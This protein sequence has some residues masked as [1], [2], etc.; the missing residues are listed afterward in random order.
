MQDKKIVCFNNFFLLSLELIQDEKNTHTQ[1]NFLLNMEEFFLKLCS[2]L[3][4]KNADFLEFIFCVYFSEIT[5]KIKMADSSTKDSFTSLL[6]FI[7]GAYSRI[8]PDASSS[9]LESLYQ[10][11]IEEQELLKNSDIFKHLLTFNR[12]I[13]Q[14]T[15]KISNSFVYLFIN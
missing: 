15:K 2:S 4:I 10:K 11:F 1:L 13:Y 8:F 14:D 7:H 5:M 3:S 6:L 9:H 12:S